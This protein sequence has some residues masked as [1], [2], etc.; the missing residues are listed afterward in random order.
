M[1]QEHVLVYKHA[2]DYV[3]RSESRE[4]PE[5]EE[6]VPNLSTNYSFLMS[7]AE[8]ITATSISSGVAV[9]WNCGSRG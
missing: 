8:M 1:R 6:D 3:Q 5:F 9:G 7:A 4:R 2:A